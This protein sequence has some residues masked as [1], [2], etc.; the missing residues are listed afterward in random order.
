VVSALNLNS[1]LLTSKKSLPLSV[2]ALLSLCLLWSVVGVVAIVLDAGY[3]R[4]FA[5]Q[6]AGRPGLDY[7]DID[8]ISRQSE[9]MARTKP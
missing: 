1:M 4:H 6:V 9:M 2:V 7:I 3:H 8:A 5:E